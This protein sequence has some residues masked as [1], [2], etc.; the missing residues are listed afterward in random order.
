MRRAVPLKYVLHFLIICVAVCQA[1]SQERTSTYR[2]I[3]YVGGRTD[4][5]HIGAE[6]LTHIN[7]AFAQVND[8]GEVVL[9]DPEASTHLNQLT[10]L[11]TRNPNLKIILSVG[12]WGADNFSN[13]ALSDH[14]RRRFS[15]SAAGLLRAYALDGLDVDWEYPGQPGPGIVYRSED[16]QNFTLL[17]KTLR[18][19]F[20]APDTRQ[21]RRYALTIASA[22]GEYFHHTEMEKLHVYLDWINVMTY[23]FFNSLTETTGHHTGLFRSQFASDSSR[24]TQ[25]SVRQHLAAGIPSEKL[26]IGAAFY[27]RGWTGVNPANNGI[28]QGYKRYADA[29]SYPQLVHEYIDKRGFQRHWDT[30]ACA[31]YLWNPDS[32]MFI[33]YDDP[34]SLK[35]K[36]LFVKSQ[37]LGGMM[38]WEHSLDPAEELLDTI[39][40]AL[41]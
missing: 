10:A 38:Y 41:R 33:S 15:Q 8:S 19:E 37:H 6:K 3:A 17:L 11:K 2:I 32:C 12:G 36:A 31:P 23:D 4:I 39:V 29:Y 28:Q 1:P 40:A 9:R 27:A 25:S 35:Q 18:E 21:A 7:Y 26:V 24:N 22:D 30:S 16:K 13:A 20:D 5:P 34:A 14:S